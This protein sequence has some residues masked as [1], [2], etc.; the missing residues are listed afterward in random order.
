[1]QFRVGLL[2]PTS[3]TVGGEASPGLTI[4]DNQP[5]GITSSI[6]LGTDGTVRQVSVSVDISH[7]YIGDLRVALMSP[8]GTETVLHNRAGGGQDNLV[9]TYTAASTPALA[10]LGGQQVRGEWVRQVRD[11]ANRD[12][13]KLNR[14]SIEI[15]V[16]PAEGSVSGEAS[17]DL[18]IPDNDPTGVA[19]SISLSHG[20]TVREV[21]VGVEI[22]HTFIG[23]LRVELLS[24]MGRRAVLH[25][26]LGGGADDLSMT[27]E[28]TAPS[29]PLS[30]L[31][32]QPCTGDWILRVADLAGRDVGKLKSWRLEVVPG[33]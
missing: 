31:V 22:T 19:S 7:T 26:R 32:G 21:K 16:V 11:L 10:T 17:P 9:A 15:G 33:D 27:Y 13:G 8:A 6:M 23:D 1:M 25:S 24:P 3:D 4:P 12:V 28:S 5:D 30:S 18:D 2:E 29:S 20:G 14:W